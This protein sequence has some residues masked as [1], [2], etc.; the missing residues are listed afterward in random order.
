M[1]TLQFHVQIRKLFFLLYSLHGFMNVRVKPNSML[2]EKYLFATNYLYV[3]QRIAV[4]L[5][6]CRD[7]NITEQKNTLRSA[8]RESSRKAG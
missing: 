3:S 5:I 2:E 6:H 7:R 4:L 1:S 8:G